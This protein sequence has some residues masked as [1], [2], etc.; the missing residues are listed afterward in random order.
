MNIKKI[1]DVFSAVYFILVT[2][3]TEKQ[4]ETKIFYKFCQTAEDLEA[5][6]N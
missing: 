3:I 2:P 6:I 4:S 5:S 1:T